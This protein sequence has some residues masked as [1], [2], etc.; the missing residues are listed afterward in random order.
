[1]NIIPVLGR[2]QKLNQEFKASIGNTMRLSQRKIGAGGVA[3]EAEC[4]LKK[5]DTEFRSQYCLHT[6][7]HTHTQEL[8]V[9]PGKISR[10]EIYLSGRT[11]LLIF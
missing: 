4:L 5:H 3:Q 8:S 11:L 9:E 7:T 6:H 2:L 10:A 1:M